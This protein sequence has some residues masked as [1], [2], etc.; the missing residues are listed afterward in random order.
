M[1]VSE[2]AVK[3]KRTC[4]SDISSG[5]SERT[6]SGRPGEK[7]RKPR[8]AISGER[9][10]LSSPQRRTG[11]SFC[12]TEEGAAFCLRKR[13]ISERTSGFTL[14]LGRASVIELMR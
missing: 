2:V 6:G 9:D 4:N 1:R 3:I 5:K 13:Q 7:F 10:C 11:E 8:E 14:R 12:A